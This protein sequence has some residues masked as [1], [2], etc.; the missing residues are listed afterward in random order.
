MITI[1]NFAQSIF[2][3]LPFK[4]QTSLIEEL[5]RPP[6]NTVIYRKFI[7]HKLELT[8]SRHE[9]MIRDSRTGGNITNDQDYQIIKETL[10][11]MWWNSYY[12]SNLEQRTQISNDLL[13]SATFSRETQEILNKIKHKEIQT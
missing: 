8:I 5:Y 1:K 4:E 13:E 6:N 12:K 2:K 11:E 7:N 9:L 3:Q 10:F